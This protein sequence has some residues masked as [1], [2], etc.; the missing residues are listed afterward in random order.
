MDWYRNI[1]MVDNV[2]RLEFEGPNRSVENRKP[3]KRYGGGR[4]NKFL[5]LT[6][7]PTMIAPARELFDGTEHM[8]TF[9]TS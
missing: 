8:P 4:R 5:K 6:A 7:N 1:D 9:E 2:D 3:N